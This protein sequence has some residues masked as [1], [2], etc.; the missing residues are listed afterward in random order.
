MIF[1]DAREGLSGDTLLAAMLGLVDDANR[2]TILERATQVAGRLGLDLRVLDIEEDGESGLGIAYREHEQSVPEERSYEA[3][4]SLLSDIQNSLGTDGVSE[5]RSILKLIFEAEGHAHK[6]PPE[7][8]HLHEIG[9]PQAILN[10]ALIGNLSAKLRK[11]GGPFVCSSIITGRGT[12]VV[13]HGAV[14]IPPPASVALLEG[15]RHE[16]GA[17]PGERATPT[18]IAAVKALIEKQT[19]EIPVDGRRRSVGFGTRRFAGR[20]G[21]TVLLLA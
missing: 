5:A 3:C 9:R 6:L 2:E 14:K 7:E 1:I 4:F 12:V 11:M 16:P 18:G 10:I 21:R 8:V 13:S 15:M 20:L 17:S 19:D